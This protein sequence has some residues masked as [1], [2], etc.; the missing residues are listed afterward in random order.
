M[1]TLVFGALV[2]VLVIW[3]LRSTGALAITFISVVI[4]SAAG[5]ITLVKQGQVVGHTTDL[6]GRS[7][8][9]V[10][11]PVAGLVTFIRGVPSMARGATL[12]NIAPVLDAPAPWKMPG[13]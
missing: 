12:V 1:P 11:A 9:D 4:P 10:V 5:A 2:L 8:G 13:K 6:L 7:T 3:G